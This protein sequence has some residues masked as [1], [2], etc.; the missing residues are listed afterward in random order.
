[1]CGRCE[2]SKSV[3]VH[4]SQDELTHA[5]LP[6]KK[7]QVGHD[8]LD[9]RVSLW[10]LALVSCVTRDS[11]K[12]VE[13]GRVEHRRLEVAEEDGSPVRWEVTKRKEDPNR[14]KQR[15]TPPLVL[16]ALTIR[17]A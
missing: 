2:H 11:D 15:P 12:E 13:T 14:V 17:V 16:I 3:T 9:I 4:F 5:I 1:M 7:R 6:L 8:P 10:H